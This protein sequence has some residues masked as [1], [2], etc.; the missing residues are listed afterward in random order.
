MRNSITMFLDDGTNLQVSW[1]DVDGRIYLENGWQELAAYCDFKYGDCLFM[2]LRS[3]LEMDL[4]LVR[5]AAKCCII[6]Q[7]Q[8]TGVLDEE[9]WKT[10][11]T[12]SKR[13]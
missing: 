2:V 1:N 3:D 13:K 10:E 4:M 8:I 12:D 5:K 11:I 6:A 9:L 7:H